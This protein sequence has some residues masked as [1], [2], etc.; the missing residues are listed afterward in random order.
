MR[1]Y[2]DFKPTP[3][4]C[5]FKTI[6]TLGTFD[7][8]HIGHQLVLQKVVKKAEQT[9]FKAAVLTF[10]RHPASLITPDV[11]PKLLTTIDEKLSIFKKIGIDTTFVLTF[12][13]SDYNGN[14]IDLTGSSIR[15]QLR[16]SY[17]SASYTAF[18]VQSPEPTLG[19]IEISLTA[20]QT[21]SLRP[22][23]YVYDI[24]VEEPEEYGGSIVRVMEG[25]VTVTP[26]VT[27]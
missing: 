18:A 11:S 4:N 25:I 26:E 16:K 3:Q 8:V 1:I 10:D 13:L 24:E 27:R 12:N 6:A 21:T 9:G 15:S 7:G 22:G 5:G 17:G 2:K 19:E 20:E 14:A 23:R